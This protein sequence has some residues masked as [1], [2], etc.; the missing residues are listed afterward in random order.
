MKNL[1]IVGGGGFFREL[2]EYCSTDIENGRLQHV[3][4]KGVVDDN[5]AVDTRGLQYLGS[6]DEYDLQEDDVLII[7]IGNPQIRAKIYNQFIMKG[8]DFYTYIHPS[9]YVSPSA[10]IGDGVIIAPHSIV[11]ANAK[12]APNVVV[13]VQCSVGHDC[14]IEMSAVL[15]PYCALSGGSKVGKECFL[16]SRVTVFPNVII[17]NKASIDAHVCVRDTVEERQ[18]LYV[19]NQY[20]KIKNRLLDD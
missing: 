1:I 15:S 10:D 12:I 8:G 6:V 19:K 9:V 16:G 13:N 11:N 17:K 5:P 18:I 3:S 14:G 20:K 2:Y 4:I 7:A